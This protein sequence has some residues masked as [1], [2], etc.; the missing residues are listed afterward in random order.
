MFSGQPRLEHSLR[1][2]PD[3]VERRTSTPPRLKHPPPAKRPF[4]FLVQQVL[5]TRPPGTEVKSA[6]VAQ[7]ALERAQKVF[8]EVGTKGLLLALAQHGVARAQTLFALAQVTF[9]RLSVPRAERP[10]APLHPRKGTFSHLCYFDFC[11]WRS[12]LQNK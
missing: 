1:S 5:Q 9:G 7:S 11:P 12:G 3:G 10:F 4:A 6:D 2:S 8:G